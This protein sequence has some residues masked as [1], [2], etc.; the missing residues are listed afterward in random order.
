MRLKLTFVVDRAVMRPEPDGR[1]SAVFFDRKGGV[2]F[3]GVFS[4]DAAKALEATAGVT[5]VDG[6]SPLA[7]ESAAAARPRRST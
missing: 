7:P 5:V 2:I 4:P 6:S 3:S 1:A